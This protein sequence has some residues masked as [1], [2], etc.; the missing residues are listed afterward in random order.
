MN[1]F[2][3][4]LQ[5]T[6]LHTATLH[7]MANDAEDAEAKANEML[8]D[9]D[10]NISWG[11]ADVQSE[12]VVSVKRTIFRYWLV[13]VFSESGESDQSLIHQNKYFTLRT[14]PTLRD[15]GFNARDYDD[16]IRS[17]NGKDSVIL[18]V[19]SARSTADLCGKLDDLNIYI[20]DETG[21]II[22]K[23]DTNIGDGNF[24]KA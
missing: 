4:I 16:A 15:N 13:G 7:I 11:F 10:S 22:A 1:E 23:E 19:M 2:K 14:T 3:V 18:A 24:V 9:H 5:R 12:V 20:I 17:L 6:A 8:N 21:H